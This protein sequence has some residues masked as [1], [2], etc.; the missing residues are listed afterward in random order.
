MVDPLMG[1]FKK[2]KL[3]WGRAPESAEIGR[4]QQQCRTEPV[5]LQWGRAPE[6]AEMNQE[7][8]EEGTINYRFNGAALRRAR[9][10]SIRKRC[11]HGTTASM[12]P[13]S[14]ERGDIVR[15]TFVRPHSP[16]S[17]G[18]RSG[19]RGDAAWAAATGSSDL[20]QWGRAPESAEIAAS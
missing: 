17:M 12:G 11:T 5:E 16:A 13:R 18:P 7:T 6:S 10:C 4:E 20:L 14:G 2:I 3:Q 19:E 15:V 9:R 8:T 1:W